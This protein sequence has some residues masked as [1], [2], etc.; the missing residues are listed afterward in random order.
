[1]LKSI[2]VLIGFTVIMLALSMAVTVV[3]QFIT[4][5]VNTRGRHLKRGLA[6]MLGQ[7][8]PELKGAV[9]AAVAKTILTHP[10][11]SGA[12]SRLGSIVHREE[13][14]KLLMQLA[15][16]TAHPLEDTAREALKKALAANGVSDPA[17]T[18]RNVRAMVLELEASNPQLAA[19]AR[20]S[21]ALLQEARSELVAKINNWFDQTM[22]RTSQRFTSTTRAI[23]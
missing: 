1:M 21:I 17:A 4:S 13:F 9:G 11:V 20:N 15:D 8:S 12:S 2:D 10:L 16:D 3:T 6:D 7:L 14:T 18:L 19:N 5:A 22:D 23:T